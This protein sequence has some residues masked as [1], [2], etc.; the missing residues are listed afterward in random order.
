MLLSTLHQALWWDRG[1]GAD[2][3]MWGN[4]FQ[5]EAAVLEMIDTPPPLFLKKEHALSDT[6]FNNEHFMGRWLL[7]AI[8]RV[9]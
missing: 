7:R 4:H 2:G 3:G 5:T 9:R 8:F 6:V 1:S